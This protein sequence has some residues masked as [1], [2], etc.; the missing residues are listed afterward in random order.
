MSRNDR[1]VTNVLITTFLFGN[2]ILKPWQYNATSDHSLAILSNL[3]LELVLGEGGGQWKWWNRVDQHVILG[4]LPF[5]SSVE[6]LYLDGV[7]AE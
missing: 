6:P 3:V 5:P 7:R 1:S 2:A 4:V